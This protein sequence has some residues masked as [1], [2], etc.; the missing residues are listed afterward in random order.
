MS[1]SVCVCG[2][3][4]QFCSHFHQTSIFILLNCEPFSSPRLDMAAM[5]LV[6][7]ALS[8]RYGHLPVLITTVNVGIIAIVNHHI[9]KSVA[10]IVCTLCCLYTCVFT[11]L[12]F[13]NNCEKC[14]YF[15][16]CLQHHNQSANRLLVLIILEYT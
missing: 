11:D 3:T 8:I 6:L 2:C 14:T 15:I 7:Q 13:R 4:R 10:S 12:S 5:A 9:Y 16:L 1:V